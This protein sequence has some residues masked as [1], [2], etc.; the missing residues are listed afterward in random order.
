VGVV[1]ICQTPLL[2]WPIWLLVA[3]K[4]AC[5]LI[6]WRVELLAADAIAQCHQHLQFVHY[7]YAL[8][9]NTRQGC[10]AGEH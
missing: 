6:L 3:V 9:I 10:R 7:L 2:I 8:K 1:P 5:V 4:M